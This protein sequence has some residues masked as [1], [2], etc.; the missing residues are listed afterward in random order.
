MQVHIWHTLCTVCSTHSGGTS[1]MVTKSCVGV[2]INWQTA[3]T[4]P[5]PKKHQHQQ[6]AQRKQQTTPGEKERKKKKGIVMSKM[7][8]SW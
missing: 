5:L 8:I 7:R 1:G 4:P 2:A 3:T 6:K